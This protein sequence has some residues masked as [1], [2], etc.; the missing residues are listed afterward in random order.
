MPRKQTAL[1][2]RS[3]GSIAAAGREAN[4]AAGLAAFV[5]YRSTKAAGTLRRQDA[6]LALFARFLREATGADVDALGIDPATWRGVTSGLVAAFRRWQL[7]EGFAIGSVN[8]RLST[9]KT[10]MALATRAG[11]VDALESA[12]ARGIV[13]YRRSEGRNVDE[14]RGAEGTPVRVGTKKADATPISASVAARLKDQPDT[15]QGRRDS[16]L[17]CLLLDHGLRCGE[18]AALDVGAIDTREETLTFY[19][20][21]VDIT[22]THRLTEDTAR[23]AAR[24]L[25]GDAPTEGPLLRE[26]RKGGALT[27]AGMSERAI[28]KRVAALG[29][30]AGVERLSAHDC[31]HFWAT[32]AARN[33]T[34]MDRLQDAGGWSSPAMPSRYIERARIANA[35]VRLSRQG[36]NL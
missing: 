32:D 30:A 36:E 14:R 12:Q 27:S 11:E 22:Q 17:M 15:A 9:V 8:V 25:D 33:G 1:V 4:R 18:V 29:R 20:R 19:R 2:R 13:G 6:D 28:T 35:G 34:P 24:Y 26:S 5:E 16:L 21:K 3:S 10:Y 7:A 23:A 31:R